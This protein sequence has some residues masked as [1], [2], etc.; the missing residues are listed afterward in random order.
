VGG[1]EE[2]WSSG[3][4]VTVRLGESDRAIF[5]RRMGSGPS[6][7]MLHAFLSSSYDWAR[8]A[9]ALSR[10]FALLLPDFL[11]F[12][13][14]EKP[15]EHSYSLQEQADLVEALWALEGTTSTVVVAHDFAVSVTQELL[16]RRA[17]GAL[18]VDLVAVHLLNGGVYPHLYRPEPASMALLDPEHG[19]TLAA[20]LTQELFALA[21]KPTFAGGFDPSEDSADIFQAATRDGGR[22]VASRLA[23]YINDRAANSERWV[24]A[25]EQTDVPVSFVWGMLDPVAGADMA[26]QIREC[27]PSAP[28]VAL[29]NVAHWPALEA[30]E[31]VTAALLGA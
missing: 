8:I 6:M 16:A 5:V 21:V 10:R 3:E 22:E 4:R 11:G 25:L 7:T 15:L 18:S 14:S 9:P 23:T 31:Q 19:P 1:I 30:S 2:W 13:A 17:E 24:A 27:C 20:T 12:G 28:F 29:D 26:D